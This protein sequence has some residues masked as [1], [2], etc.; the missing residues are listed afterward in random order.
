MENMYG[1]KTMNTI[2]LIFALLV[3]SFATAS[4]VYADVYIVGTGGNGGEAKASSLGIEGGWIGENFLLGIGYSLTN[5]DE[6]VTEGTPTSKSDTTPRGA[7]WNTTKTE[8]EN[9]IYFSGGIR[10]VDRLFLVANAGY[11]QQLVKFHSGYFNIDFDEDA[12]NRFT[13]GGQLL[14][15]Y[16]H[17]VISGGYHNRR[18]VVVELGFSF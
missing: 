18:G 9:E 7:P 8:K 13:Y 4:A 1:G 17:L 10:V 6:T 12:K 3:Y 16:K 15:N 14:Y 5:N 2:Y 11:S